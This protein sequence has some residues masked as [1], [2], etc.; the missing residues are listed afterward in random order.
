M[1]NPFESKRIPELTKEMKKSLLTVASIL[2][3]SISTLSWQ[4]EAFAEDDSEG[5]ELSSETYSPEDPDVAPLNIISKEEDTDLDPKEKEKKNKKES[6][7][8]SELTLEN[9]AHFLPI[10][11][12]SEI[13]PI[14]PGEYSGYSMDVQNTNI[15]NL[16]SYLLDGFNEYDPETYIVVIKKIM[17]TLESSQNAERSEEIVNKRMEIAEKVLLGINK[18][19]LKRI[20]DGGTEFNNYPSASQE[21]EDADFLQR[22]ARLEGGDAEGYYDAL[23]VFTGAEHRVSYIRGL[24]KYSLRQW[25]TSQK[26]DIKGSIGNFWNN[27][28]HLLLSPK[29]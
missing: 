5:P 15:T 13:Q 26:S 6:E 7:P 16:E 11:E 25:F 24:Q 8:D 10:T 21:A 27:T 23:P 2:L 28:R 18:K 29:E 20:S 4:Q 19:L 12:A 22:Q 3:L 14:L 1:K 9:A 17:G